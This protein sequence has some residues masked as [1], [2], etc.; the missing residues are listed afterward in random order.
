MSTSKQRLYCNFCGQHFFS[1]ERFSA[2]LTIH[3]ENNNVSRNT[4]YNCKMCSVSFE[5]EEKLE[6]HYGTNKHRFFGTKRRRNK[7][8]LSNV[9][10]KDRI[11]DTINEIFPKERIDP[12]E[13]LVIS[14]P[15]PNMAYLLLQQWRT[16]DSKGCS[17]AE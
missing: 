9:E 7:E 4:F 12:L 17:D 11:D 16:H 1:I 8:S 5:N 15:F 14:Q 13:S 3:I 2:H 10:I 6:E